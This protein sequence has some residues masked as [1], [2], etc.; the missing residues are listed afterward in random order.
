MRQR[1]PEPDNLRS[2]LGSS[3]GEIGA[4]TPLESGT[5]GSSFLIET[6][7]SRFVAKV[8]SPQS[9]TL[10]GPEAQFDLLGRLESTGIAP[11]PAACVP[12]AGILVTR[13]IDAAA[14]VGTAEI[15]RPARIREIGDLL[16]RL[17]RSG[18]G[19]PKFDPAS[20][21]K[22][23]FDRLGGF[24]RLSKSNRK[25][26]A[27]LLDLA[28]S[29]DYETTCLCHN[30]LSADNILF[31]SSSKLIDFD[32]ATLA[33]PILDLASVSVMNGFAPADELQLF[34]ACDTVA[35]VP[36]FTAEFARVKRL[37][38]LLSHFWSL[39]SSDPGAAIVSQYRIDDV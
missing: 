37:V 17:H 1:P 12:S 39:A 31:G 16:G 15:K 38:Q 27:E 13:Y 23:Y 9:D 24:E 19:A 33:P 3:L 10:L 25:L 21:A 8:F 36:N 20:Y 2:L 32:Y 6:A 22:K 14:A 35:K 28:T 18:V 11:M 4:I 26:G 30:D 5:T 29:L 7:A 34:D